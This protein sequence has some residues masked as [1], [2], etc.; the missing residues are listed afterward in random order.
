V[1]EKERK[2]EEEGK[3]IIIQSPKHC[4]LKGKQDDV[5]DKNKTMDN[6][7]KRHICTEENKGKKVVEEERTQDTNIRKARE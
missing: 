1:R 7:Q 5:L 2:V 4:G 3:Q 6:V